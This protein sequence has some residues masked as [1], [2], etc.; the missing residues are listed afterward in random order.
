M[1]EVGGYLPGAA[2]VL[3]AQLAQL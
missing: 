2:P 3:E 1:G